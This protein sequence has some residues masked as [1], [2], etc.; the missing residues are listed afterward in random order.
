MIDIQFD[1][2]SKEFTHISDDIS[3]ED[4]IHIS[5]SLII[6]LCTCANDVSGLQAAEDLGGEFCAFLGKNLDR[7]LKEAQ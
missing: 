7:I 1:P 5:A 3:P 6:G 2:V 4:I